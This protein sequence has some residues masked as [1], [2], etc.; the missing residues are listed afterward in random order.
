MTTFRQ[1]CRIL[2]EAVPL[3]GAEDEARRYEINHALSE[4]QDT[5]DLFRKVKYRYDRW[6]SFLP[7]REI[8]PPLSNIGCCEIGSFTGNELFKIFYAI[9]FNSDYKPGNVLYFSKFGSLC[10]AIL[11]THSTPESITPFCPKKDMNCRFLYTKLF[12]D[13]RVEERRRRNQQYY[14]KN[15]IR[16]HRNK[17][18]TEFSIFLNT[19]ICEFHLYPYGNAFLGL[20]TSLS[21]IISPKGNPQNLLS[22]PADEF[23]PFAAC[24]KLAFSLNWTGRITRLFGDTVWEA[25][26]PMS[27]RMYQRIDQTS[28]DII[29]Q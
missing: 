15:Y 17:A 8:P 4:F 12:D 22:L 25:N 21:F 20:L 16:E 2:T 24:V 18:I 11:F 13:D 14:E 7:A 28:R 6:I 3:R 27:V 23:V 9:F 29:E 10:A 5:E 1:T 19:K 26:P